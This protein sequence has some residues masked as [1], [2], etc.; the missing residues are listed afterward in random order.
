M[1]YISTNHNLSPYTRVN[2]PLV[3]SLNVSNHPILEFFNLNFGYHIEH[4]L[5][6]SMPASKSK[7]VSKKLQELYPDKYYIMPKF[8]A[9]KK[10]YQTPRIYKNR[11]ILIHPITKKEYA[12]LGREAL[13]E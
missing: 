5:F 2:D 10:L 8:E 7:I 6:P 11:D 12:T 1:S 13:V 3:N 4:H 9:I